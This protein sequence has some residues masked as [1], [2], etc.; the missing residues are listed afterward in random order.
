M[1]SQVANL[2]APIT[3]NTND[4]FTVQSALSSAQ[5]TLQNQI[6]NL[7]TSNTQIQSG[8]STVKT[9][10]QKLKI[11]C[12]YNAGGGYSLACQSG[13]IPV[14]CSCGFG[15]GSWSI[16]SENTCRCECGGDWVRAVCCKIQ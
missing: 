1:Q 13:Y 7:Q 11:T 2:N 6:N 9:D 8:L 15:C 16:Q 14:A 5:T 3:K 10:M 12:T 4:I